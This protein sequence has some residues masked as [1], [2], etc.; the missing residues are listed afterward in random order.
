M[1]RLIPHTGAALWL[2]LDDGLISGPEDHLRDLR[3]FLKR[4]VVESVTA[5]LGFRGA[6]RSCH[7]ELA[8]TPTIMN[9]TAST[10][11]GEHTRKVVVGSVADAVRDGVDAV[12]CHVNITSAYEGEQLEIL[13]RV[14]SEA[15]AYG[16]PVV[17]MAYPRRRH[18]NGTDDNH[19]GLREKNPDEFAVLVRHGV[20]AAVE[21]GASAVKTIYTGTVESFQTVVDCAMDVPV[22][23]AGE[24]LIDEGDAVAKAQYAIRA[25]AAGVAFG[26]QIFARHDPGPFVHKL[27]TGIDDCWAERN[28]TVTSVPPRSNALLGGG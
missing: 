4:D 24:K 13:G 3:P 19:L 28:R 1:T 21:L 9:L 10:T 11:L 27:R 26:R 7:R 6:L 2:P 22:L 16:M 8:R 14:V 18:P 15:D 23:I 5:V 12:A 20:R 25:G 17:A